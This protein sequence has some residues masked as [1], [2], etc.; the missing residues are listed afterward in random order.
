MCNIKN[1]MF[2]NPN[3]MVKFIKSQLNQT[4]ARTTIFWFRHRTFEL[5]H[6]YITFLLNNE[7]IWVVDCKKKNKCKWWFDKSASIAGNKSQEHGISSNSITSC[8]RFYF[9]E[10]GDFAVP[11]V[12][13]VIFLK[14]KCFIWQKKTNNTL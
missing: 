11:I 13:I 10:R 8:L 5:L 14:K 2:L 1:V 7:I 9:R 6:F 4:L 3:F 12:I